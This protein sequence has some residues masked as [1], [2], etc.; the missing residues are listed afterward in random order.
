MIRLQ[1]FFKRFVCLG[2][3]LITAPNIFAS[4]NSDSFRSVTDQRGVPVKVPMKIER[5]VTICDGLVESVMTALGVQNSI[6]GLGSACIPKHWEYTYPTV[7][8]ES[9]GYTDG[10]NTVTFLNP[11]FMDLPLV[12]QSGT[13]IN[14]ETLASLNPDVVFLRVGSCT[15]S[16]NDES[17]HK[18]IRMIE[19]LGIP[20]VV[21]FGPNMTKNPKM[22]SISEEIRII[23]RA[24]GNEQKATALAEYLEKQV[25]FVMDRTREIP[26]DQK[27]SVLL[28][29]LSPK[30]REA[31]GT[32]HVRGLNTID[33]WLVETVVNA[34]NAFRTKGAWNIL[35]TEQVLAI[36]PDVIVL[37]TAWGYHP[38]RE[39]YEAPYYQNLK[40]LR[41]VRNRRVTALPWTPC[42]CDKRLEYPIDIMIMAKAA[43]PER[44]A[45]VDLNVW[46]LDFYQ[47]VYGVDKK[48]A[49]QLRAVQWMDW[50]TEK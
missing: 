31:G 45:D 42:N 46:L 27:P 4:E 18:T 47:N 8:G 30:S 37:I 7:A 13:G 19:S 11:F 26:E 49:A 43:Y 17:T 14:Y 39:L 32:G 1:L 16:A 2:I 20:L 28:F 6:V 12:A 21:L 3:F 9:Y 5:V 25:R 24:L 10:M 38:P 29:G 48:T 44:F 35:G 50:I 41:A 22:D 23:G 34:R 40:D 33:S 36:D 15:L